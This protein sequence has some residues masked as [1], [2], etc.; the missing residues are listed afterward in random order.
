MSNGT[1]GQTDSSCVCV[2][3]CSCMGGWVVVHVS[4]VDSI[5]TT[6]TDKRSRYTGNV[7]RLVVC[8]NAVHMLYYI[9][10]QC[11]VG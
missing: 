10:V 9:F 4:L 6:G 11:T 7:R 3:A 2:C 5:S 8:S 1:D